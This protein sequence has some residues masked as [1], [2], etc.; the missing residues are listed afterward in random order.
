MLLAAI[1]TGCCIGPFSAWCRSQSEFPMWYASSGVL[2]R[3]AGAP[4]I[5]LWLVPEHIVARLSPVSSQTVHEEDR[6]GCTGL[7]APVATT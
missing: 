2:A 7:R 4:D 1:I 3:N 5:P 6:N